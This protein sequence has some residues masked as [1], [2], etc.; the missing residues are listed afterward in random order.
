MMELTIKGKVYQFKFG[1]GFMREI[2]RKITRNVDDTNIKKNIGLQFN[3]A[4]V[5]DGDVEALCNILLAA[6]KGYSPRLTSEDLDT[7][8]DDENTDIDQLF[9]DVLGFLETANATKKTYNSLMKA[10]EEEQKK[11]MK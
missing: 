8:I 5:I 1:M 11:Q 10:I 3:I 9:E 2:N 4:S 6:N 7:F